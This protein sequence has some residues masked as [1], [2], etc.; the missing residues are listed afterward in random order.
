MKK[1]LAYIL[2]CMM[3]LWASPTSLAEDAVFVSL[4]EGGLLSGTAEV[5]VSGVEMPEVLVDDA[6]VNTRL[7]NCVLAFS[8]VGMDTIGGTLHCEDQTFT[9]IEKNGSIY[10]IE[11]EKRS[12]SG[13]DVVLTYVPSS[14][15]FTYGEE[16]VYGQYNLDDHNISKV[17]LSLPDSSKITPDHVI[18]YYPVAGSSEITEV[19]EAY[20]PQTVYTIG[21]GWDEE[22]NLGGTTPESP[23]YISFEFTGLA[24]RLFKDDSHVASFD[25]TRLADGKHTLSV[26][27]GETLLKEVSFSVDNTG[28]EITLD[29]TFGE[30]LAETDCIL[31]SAAD[32]SGDVKLFGDIDGERYFPGDDLTYVYEGNHLLTVTA[33]DVCGNVSVVCKEFRICKEAEAVSDAL[34][35]QVVDAAMEGSKGIYTYN[36]GNAKKFVFEYL[37]STNENGPISVSAYDHIA[38]EYVEIGVAESGVRAVFNVEEERFILG[39]AV[40]IAVSPKLCVSV[41]DTVVWI[42]DTQYYSNFEDLNHVYELMLNYSVD[43]YQKGEAGYLIHTGDIVDTHYDSQKA[44]EEWLFAHNVHKILDESGMPNGVLAGNHDTGNTPPVLDNYKRYFG[45]RRYYQNS[46]Y[47]GT[48]DN[49]GCHYDL[50][51][52]GDEDYLFLYLSNG[53]EATD[54]TVAW[55]NAVCQAYAHRTVILCVHPY[56]DVTGNYVYNPNDTG[57]YNH[58]RAYEIAEKIISPNPNV[59]AVLCGHVHGA[60]RVQREF[61]EGRYVW[62]ILS[63]YQYAEVGVEPKH[64]ENGCSLD[65]EGYLRLITFGERGFM[66][67]TTYSPLHNDYNFFEDEEDSFH[68]ILQTAEGGVTLQTDAA[69]IYYEAAKP[70]MVQPETKSGLP[71][72]L[73]IVGVLVAVDLAGTLIVILAKKRKKLKQILENREE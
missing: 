33:T 64:E 31:F 42:T 29:L 67:H 49:N 25:T 72:I 14:T 55:A 44:A 52:I 43:L 62:E 46:W 17:T 70:A 6:K 19:R 5:I 57:A 39:G 30:A 18:L 21:D 40:K 63:D 11:F 38:N 28:P 50:L 2:I 15:G 27:K 71:V 23:I 47:G 51:T 10:G 35:K 7:G 65:G 53:V 56:L 60:K 66:E 9:S 26:M 12:F 13:E 8:A 54:L 36:I 73:L 59:A 3:L 45:K 61:G 16:L 22:T 68:V 58:S 32:P 1:A 4:Q 69:A 34:E 37:G 48:P 24:K 20:S 41:S